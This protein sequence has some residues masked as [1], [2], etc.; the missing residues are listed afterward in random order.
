MLT[1]FNYSHF[2]AF[3]LLVFAVVL[4]ILPSTS[5][6]AAPECDTSLRGLIQ[7]HDFPLAFHCA[8]LRFADDPEDMD[9]LLVMARAAQELGQAELAGVLATQARTHTLT[10]AQSFAAYLISGISQARQENLITAKILL[11]RASDFARAEAEQDVVRR[12]L[13]QTNSLSPWKFSAG[14]GVLP[15]TNVN[16]GSLHDTIILGGLEFVLDD[17]AKAQSGIAYSVSGAVTHQTRLSL[18][19][20]Y[21][22]GQSVK[23]YSNEKKEYQNDEETEVFRSV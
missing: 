15:S 23:V 18:K 22:I 16:A 8:E 6:S 20:S 2:R 3:V 14:I 4:S 1:L 7:S 10:T 17:D 12:L 9:A 11:Y 13:S 21:K 19:W 5:R